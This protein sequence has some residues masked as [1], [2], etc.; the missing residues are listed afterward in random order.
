MSLAL[1]TL[2]ARMNIF[3]PVF[4][5][6]EVRKVNA[7]D[8]AIRAYRVL[9][10]PPWVL[11]KTTLRLF[12]NI[13]TYPVPS[14]FAA[15]AILDSQSNQTTYSDRPRYV[16]TSLTDF[17]ADPDYRNRIAEIWEGGIKALGVRNKTQDNLTEAGFD[18]ASSV[19]DWTD[20]GDAGALSV[21]DAVTYN[22]TETVE[23]PI[24]YSTGLAEVDATIT[25]QLTLGQWRRNYFFV[26][27]YIGAA[28]TSLRLKVGLDNANYYLSPIITTQ[29]SGQPFIIGDWNVV[30]VDLNT[31]TPIGTPTDVFGFQGVVFNEA[32]TGT[33]YIGGSVFR[34]WVEEQFWYYSKNNVVTT[35]GSFQAYFAPDGATYDIN[36]ELIGDD[37]WFDMVWLFAALV[38]LSD[39]KETTIFAQVQEMWR[40]ASNA[41]YMKYPDLEPRMITQVYTFTDDFQRIMTLGINNYTN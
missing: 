8:Q 19:D 6:D 36:D 25:S 1:S 11:Q 24:V 13:L 26:P 34:G 23:V 39:Q 38:L 3:T 9:V 14:D 22:G 7:I 12:K 18:P 29:F 27:I 28:T 17:L 37:V 21:S 2:L 31:A 15:L 10:S 35:T 41:F 4:V 5:I 40:Q 32:Q 33:Y 20:S 16:F 30:A